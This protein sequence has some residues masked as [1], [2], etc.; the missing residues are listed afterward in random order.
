MKK[1]ILLINNG[2]ASTTLINL[3]DQ[4]LKFELLEPIKIE[5]IHVTSPENCEIDDDQEDINSKLK[6]NLKNLRLTHLNREEEETIIPTFP[7][8]FTDMDCLPQA[9]ASG[10]L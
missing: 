10:D 8:D 4:P 1:S 9:N 6:D 5:S 3:T 2:K 7:M